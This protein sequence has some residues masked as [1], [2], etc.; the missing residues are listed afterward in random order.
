MAGLGGGRFKRE[1]GK[2]QK[3][4]EY[5]AGEAPRAVESNLPCTWSLPMGPREELGSSP[6]LGTATAPLLS[7][8]LRFQVPTCA[9]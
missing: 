3:P 1:E 6:V 5:E 9:E 2:E 7:H 4:T 8:A